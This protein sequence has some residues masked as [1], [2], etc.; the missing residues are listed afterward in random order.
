[1]QGIAPRAKRF[2]TFS[3]SQWGP[4]KILSG[5]ENQ[6][7]S[8]FVRSHSD[9][10]VEMAGG[11]FGGQGPLRRLSQYSRLRRRQW[12]WEQRNEYVQDKFLNLQGLVI[13][14]LEE[15]RE[16]GM[17]REIRIKDYGYVTV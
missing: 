17:G 9:C 4:L 6:S 11:R 10:S 13:Y 16:R 7:H 14:G 15:E 3:K 5:S 12:E 1:M 2:G 8:I